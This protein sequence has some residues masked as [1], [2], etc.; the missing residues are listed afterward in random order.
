MPD[1][2]T[3]RMGKTEMSPR[4]LA[5]GAAWLNRQPRNEAVGAIR[6]ALELG[7]DYIDTY[8]GHNEQYWGEALSGAPRDDYYL[9]AKVGTHP[10]RRKD[11]SAETARWSVTNSLRDLRVDYLDAVLIHDPDDMDDVLGSGRA[12][13]ELLKMRDEGLVKHLGLGVRQHDFHRRIIETGEAGVILTYL[14]YTLLD[15]SVETT[16]FPL[17]AE[18]DVGLILA[19]PLG[20]GLLTGV[21][22]DPETDRRRHGGRESPAHDM[23]RW[24]CDRDTNIRHLAMQFCL[25]APVGG[26]VMFGPAD[27]RQV[28]EGYEAA[29]TEIPDDIWRDFR[30]EFGVGVDTAAA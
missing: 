2:P 4:S 8:P 22:P 11:F 14:D 19:S 28:E 25:A 1:L 20:M 15:R 5:L 27:T 23:W 10:E 29:T 26:I 6:R 16:T 3:R 17:A 12:F 24:C 7:I 30:A 13:E 18:R 21:E 9:Q